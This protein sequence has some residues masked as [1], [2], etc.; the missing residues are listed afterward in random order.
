MPPR[1]YGPGTRTSRAYEVA[2][3]VR[4]VLDGLYCYLGCEEHSKHRSLLDCFASDHASGCDICMREAET[5]YE[6]TSEASRWTRSGPRSTAI[7]DALPLIPMG[8]D[9][10]RGP[11][12]RLDSAFAGAGALAVENLDTYEITD[13]PAVVVWRVERCHGR[14][15]RVLG[16]H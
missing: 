4:T 3:A 8:W 15:C 13:D 14:L 9:H 1:R 10:W 6:M 11:K 16:I 7:T 5:P 12:D 2:W